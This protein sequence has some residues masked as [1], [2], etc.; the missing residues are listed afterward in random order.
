MDIWADTERSLAKLNEELARSGDPARVRYFV[1][2]PD[3][4][5]DGELVT[6]IWALPPPVRRREVWSVRKRLNY[7]RM[8]EHRL[9]GV[10]RLVGVVA[11]SSLFRTEK[12]ASK[13]YRNAQP[14]PET[15]DGVRD[16][17]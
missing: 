16:S 17:R 8:L 5:W 2:Q 12:K 1:I 14:V 11:T 7:E 15:A 10:D 9:V 6:A 13:A 4:D 3:P